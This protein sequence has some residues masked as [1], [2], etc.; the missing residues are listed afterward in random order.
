[1]SPDR[2]SSS[3]EPL[4]PLIAH[5]L[6]G[7]IAGGLDCFIRATLVQCRGKPEPERAG[8]LDCQSALG[9]DDIPY[10]ELRECLL[11]NYEGTGESMGPSLP[12]AHTRRRALTLMAG[13]LLFAATG[14]R[15]PAGRGL[16]QKFMRGLG[17][18]VGDAAEKVASDELAQAVESQAAPQPAQA[19]CPADWPVDCNEFCCAAGLICCSFNE[20]RH[21]CQPCGTG[22]CPGGTFCCSDQ[23]CCAAG[24]SCYSQGCCDPDHKMCPDGRCAPLGSICCDDGRYCGG[25]ESCCY[26]WCCAA[27]SSCDSQGCCPPGYGRC[28]DGTCAPLG[29]TCCD[30]GRHCG[31]TESCCS[32]Q[33]CCAA[34]YSCYSQGCCPPGYEMCPDGRCWPLG[35]TC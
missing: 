5:S 15:G 7:S 35:S 34:G 25:T 16:G 26:Q 3:V 14:C 31:G 33:W 30:N 4:P 2:Q 18:V 20:T 13:V 9:A 11:G 27:G 12:A 28:P 32:D 23:W 22:G 1:M 21:C 24:S 29:S 6:A 17:A 19:P 8:N 10:R